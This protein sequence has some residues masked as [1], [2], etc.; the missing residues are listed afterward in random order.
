MLIVDDNRDA[1]ESSSALLQAVGYE[2]RVAYDGV[3][4][5]AEVE[6]FHPEIVL[7]D[8]GLPGMDGLEV[9]RRLGESESGRS[10]LLVAVTGWGQEQDRQRS[11][12]AGFARHLV[13]PVEPRVLMETLAELLAAR[14]RATT[15]R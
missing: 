2:T 1:A 7:L 13:K 12:E 11:E 8:I 5:L 15:A 10:A 9:A 6:A 3:A 4:A 14:R